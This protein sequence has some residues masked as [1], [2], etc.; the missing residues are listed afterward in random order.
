MVKGHRGGQ[1]LLR[2]VC[3]ITD[4]DNLLKYRLIYIVTVVIKVSISDTF[5]TKKFKVVIFLRNY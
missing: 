2:G 4:N 5:F 1:G 3:C